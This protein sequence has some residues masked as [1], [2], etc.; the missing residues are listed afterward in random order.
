VLWAIIARTFISFDRSSA[1]QIRLLIVQT[2]ALLEYVWF[3]ASTLV[4]DVNLG[5]HP[6]DTA[7]LSE[8]PACSTVVPRVVGP[9]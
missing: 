6:R 5:T 7:G 9:V 4:D 3:L 8:P 1:L 2:V